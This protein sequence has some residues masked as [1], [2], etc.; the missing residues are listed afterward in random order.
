VLLVIAIQAVSLTST[1]AFSAFAILPNKNY[2]REQD[3][4]GGFGSR[5]FVL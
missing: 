3:L 5:S 2:K 1:I 4:G